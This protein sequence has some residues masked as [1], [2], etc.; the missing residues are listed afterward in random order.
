[1]HRGRDPLSLRRCLVVAHEIVDVMQQRLRLGEV[2]VVQ[3]IDVEVQHG[4]C[5][6]AGSHGVGHKISGARCVVQLRGEMHRQVVIGGIERG[7]LGVLWVEVGEVEKQIAV[8]IRRAARKTW[9]NFIWPSVC[10]C[11]AIRCRARSRPRL[12]MLCAMTCTFSAPQFA[13]KSTRES[14]IARSLASMLASST[15]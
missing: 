7:V 10:A 2:G 15:G 14:V 3:Q 6:D 4:H 1:M 9:P 13:V 11:D 5:V 12:P 8:H